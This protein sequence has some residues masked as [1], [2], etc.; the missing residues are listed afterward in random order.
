MGKAARI[1]KERLAGTRKADGKWDKL[2]AGM[3]L[4][5]PTLAE[6]KATGNKPVV[7][8][9]PTRVRLQGRKNTQAPRVSKAGAQDIKG[10]IKS[11]MAKN[12]EATSEGQEG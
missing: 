7:V 1:K 6:H 2:P 9:L 4:V 8:P 5:V 10:L 12:V 11:L 3:M